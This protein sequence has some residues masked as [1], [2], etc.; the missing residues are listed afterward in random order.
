MSAG[1]V[2]VEAP[3]GAVHGFSGH[4]ITDSS[5]ISYGCTDT[6]LNAHRLTN[7]NGLNV[8]VACRRQPAAD[9][10]GQRL[11]EQVLGGKLQLHFITNDTHRKSSNPV[12][13]SLQGFAAI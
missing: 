11:I 8:S 9:F 7:R 12:R 10:G 1:P 2:D 6:M 5:I 3:L 4:S 13:F